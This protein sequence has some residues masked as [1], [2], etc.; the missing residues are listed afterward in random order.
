MLPFKFIT[1]DLLGIYPTLETLIPQMVLLAVTAVTFAMQLRKA[2][3]R[4]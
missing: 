2:K 3:K 4:L 1:V